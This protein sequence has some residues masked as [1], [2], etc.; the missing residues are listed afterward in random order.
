MEKGNKSG[1]KL[2]AFLFAAACALGL[3]AQPLAAQVTIPQGSTIN[4]AVFH[5]YVTTAT[6]H[7]VTIHRLTAEW[8]ETFVTYANFGDSY[9]SAIEGGFMTDAVGWKEVNLLSL[10]Q[11][12]ALGAMAGGYNN[13]GIAMVES[14]ESEDT[15]YY[16]S[17]DYD[18]DPTLRPKLVIGYTPLGGSPTFVTIQ[19]PGETAEYVVDS[20]IS[21]VHPEENF[22]TDPQLATR[23]N[24]GQ[25]KYSLVRFAFSITPS[26]PGTGTPGYWMNHSEAWPEDYDQILIGELSYSKEVAIELMRMA[27]AGDKTYTMFAAL[28]AAKLNAAIGCATVCPNANIS[29]TISSADAWMALFPVGS[30]VA[31]GGKNSPWRAGEPLYIMLDNYNNGLLCVPHRD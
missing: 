7:A 18:S 30:G 4:S 1:L 9:D 19:R 28:V 29:E 8:A 13:F 11:L 23:I 27:V 17:S 20:L 25:K 10:V 24:Y 6:N 26:C 22:G 14:T 21:A 15:T 5:I 3:A 2:V 31:A 12:W 16:W